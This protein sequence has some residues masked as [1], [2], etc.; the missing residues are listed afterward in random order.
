[1]FRPVVWEWWGFPRSFV[2][3][4]FVATRKGRAHMTIFPCLLA[5]MYH[6]SQESEL[7]AD[8]MQST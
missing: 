6:V 2:Y 5:Y 3:C 4:M 7:T 1:M 8:L